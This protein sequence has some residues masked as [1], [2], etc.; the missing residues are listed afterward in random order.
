MKENNS[1]NKIMNDKENADRLLLNLE[2]IIIAFGLTFLLSLVFVAAFVDMALWLRIV[3]IVSGFIICLSTC[4]IALEIER[5]A[6][7][8]ECPKCHHKYI[9]TYKEILLSMHLGRTRHLKCP[10]CKQKAW[11]KK[12]LK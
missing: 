9:P 6:G 1:L 10:N 5:V 2:I 3:L 12:V 4:F 7:F 11:N 8:Y